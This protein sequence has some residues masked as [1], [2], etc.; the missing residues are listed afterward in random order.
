MVKLFR[1]AFRDALAASGWSFAYVEKVSGVSAEQLKKVSQGKSK[2]TNV[3]DAVRVAHAFGL[4]MDEF[5]GDGTMAD[6]AEIVRLWQALTEAERDLL[7][8]A[9]R[10]RD[11][12]AQEGE[13]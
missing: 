11:A 5:L 2:S 9:A 3:D 7:R 10:G 12:L 8:A 1:D 4:S 6:R 13:K